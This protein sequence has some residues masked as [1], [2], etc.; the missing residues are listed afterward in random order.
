MVQKKFRA[1]DPVSKQLLLLMGQVLA[2][3]N[4]AQPIPEDAWEKWFSEEISKLQNL[5][6]QKAAHTLKEIALIVQSALASLV[7]EM[8]DSELR[9]ALQ[10]MQALVGGSET[11]VIVNDP[12]FMGKWVVS[13]LYEEEKGILYGHIESTLV[14][15]AV[16]DEAVSDRWIIRIGPSSNSSSS[17]RLVGESDHFILYDGPRYQPGA[18]VLYQEETPHFAMILGPNFRERGHLGYDISFHQGGKLH[19][20]YAVS[21]QNLSPVSARNS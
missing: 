14:F 15:P 5:A 12:L 16:V 2:V 11:G 4:G 6:S 17:Y 10:A 20:R 9:N 21:A 8:I 18:E 1:G 7:Y 13:R 3:L 19:H